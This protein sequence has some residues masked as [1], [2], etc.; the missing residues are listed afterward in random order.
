MQNKKNPGVTIFQ[1]YM[2]TEAIGFCLG[3]GVNYSG[4]LPH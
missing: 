3:L 4:E 1:C 2:P